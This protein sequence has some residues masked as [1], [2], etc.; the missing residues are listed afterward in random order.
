MGSGRSGETVLAGQH[1]VL[2]DCAEMSRRPAHAA[3]SYQHR[4]C[5]GQ[6]ASCGAVTGTGPRGW[7]PKLVFDR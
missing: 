5:Q 4:S 1:P 3:L 7:R 2:A 6:L